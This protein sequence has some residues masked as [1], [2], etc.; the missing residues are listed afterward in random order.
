MDDDIVLSAGSGSYPLGQ[1]DGVFCSKMIGGRKVLVQNFHHDDEFRHLLMG[2]EENFYAE[3]QQLFPNLETYEITFSDEYDAP[4]ESFRL[5]I[6][7]EEF[8]T[9]ITWDDIAHIDVF[10]V[11]WFTQ[12]FPRHHIICRRS[13]DIVP[14][15]AMIVYF[16]DF[17]IIV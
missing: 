2:K 6:E 11:S 8:Q 7:D 5:Q 9:P 14:G 12:N 13:S 15:D 3:L 17:E 10:V 1:F 4:T 16:I